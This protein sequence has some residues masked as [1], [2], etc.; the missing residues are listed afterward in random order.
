MDQATAYSYKNGKRPWQVSVKGKQLKGGLPCC[1]NL[2]AA[3]SQMM[4]DS[5]EFT[6]KLASVS[7]EMQAIAQ[8]MNL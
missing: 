3:R 4:Q 5:K 6:G 1:S 2:L 7:R 8:L